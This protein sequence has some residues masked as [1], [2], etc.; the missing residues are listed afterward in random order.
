MSNDMEHETVDFFGNGL[1]THCHFARQELE[2]FRAF[3]EASQSASGIPAG[4][5]LITGDLCLRCNRESSCRQGVSRAG[6]R[7]E[8]SRPL[9][10]YRARL[11]TIT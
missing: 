10:R 5:L 2:E 4:G 3:N 1:C 6:V 9:N 11:H 7:D 8:P